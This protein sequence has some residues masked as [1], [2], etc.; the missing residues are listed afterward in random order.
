M[1]IPTFCNSDFH[2]HWIGPNMG[3]KTS[4]SSLREKDI[5]EAL[6]RSGG[7]GRVQFLAEQLNISDETVRRIV[8]N[9]EMS[10]HVRKV[11]GG[12]FLAEDSVEPPLPSRMNTA[13]AAKRKIAAELAGLIK[14]GD[15]LFLDTGSTTA[16]CALAL[17]NHHDLFV[18]TNSLVVAQSLATR[19]NNRVYF[20]GGLLR[21]HDG[22]SFGLEAAAFVR[23]FKVKYAVLS[24]GAINTQSGFTLHDH[25]EAE[26]SGH[27]SQHAEVR[28]VV[29]DSSKFGRT[30][31]MIP[32]PLAHYQMLITDA[33]PGEDLIALLAQNNVMIQVAGSYPGAH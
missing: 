16:Y 15:S 4:H 7:Q 20:A 11:H 24:V 25:D 18:V 26:F 23:K 9:L 2:K 10:G 30:A 19:N 13:A 8:R 6:R 31:P 3:K 1:W 22:G 21:S 32:H 12:V 14:N 27:V 5:L 29:A 17:Q 28:I 33:L